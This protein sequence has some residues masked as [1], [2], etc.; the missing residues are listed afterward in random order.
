MEMGVPVVFPSKTPERI[1]TRSLSFR[2]LVP[3]PWPGFLLSI[4]LW[5][6]SSES[7]N[8][9]GQPSMTTPRALP[10]DSPHVVTLKSDPI[11]FPPISSSASFPQRLKALV[12][13]RFP[14]PWLKDLLE[15]P[16]PSHKRGPGGPSP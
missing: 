16:M 6:S 2:G 12:S 1:L 5:R 10:W 8:L 11:E 3:N 14:H 4:S 7:S 13:S 9:G 15:R